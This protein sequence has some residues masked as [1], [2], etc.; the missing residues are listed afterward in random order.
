MVSETSI[1]GGDGG[2]GS[3]SGVVRTNEGA[4]SSTGCPC[5]GNRHRKGRAGQESHTIDEFGDALS[6]V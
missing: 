5:G 6:T 4:G 2:I 1:N 3:V